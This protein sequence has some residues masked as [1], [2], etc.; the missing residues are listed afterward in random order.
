MTPEAAAV[1]DAP[2]AAAAA[3]WGQRGRLRLIGDVAPSVPAHRGDGRGRLLRGRAILPP[4]PAPQVGHGSDVAAGRRPAARAGRLPRRSL[5]PCRRGAHRG[6]HAARLA[7]DRHGH[8]SCAAVHRRRHGRR[9]ERGSRIS[10][11]SRSSQASNRTPGPPLRVPL[12]T[13]LAAVRGVAGPRGRHARGRRPG[14]GDGGGRRR[15]GCPGRRPADDDGRRTRRGARCRARRP[16]RAPRPRQRGR[17]R[18]GGA[19]RAPVAHECGTGGARR[20]RGRGASRGDGG[21]RPRS[22]RPRLLARPHGGGARRRP[23]AGVRARGGR[24]FGRVRRA[25]PRGAYD[26]AAG[27]GRRGGRRHGP[28]HRGAR[29]RGRG[30]GASGPTAAGGRVAW[31]A[32]TRACSRDPAGRGRGAGGAAPGP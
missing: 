30:D 17:A 18:G 12:A 29:R 3:L 23:G 16:R 19:R 26:R 24:R 5:D 6:C 28:D 8:A 2:I 11:T 31:S 10:P 4:G 13:S 20:G 27:R 22:R 7:R 21:R 32:R 25:R 14:R 9:R 15:A 1:V